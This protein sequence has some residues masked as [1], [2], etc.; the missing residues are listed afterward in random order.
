LIKEMVEALVDVTPSPHL[1]FWRTDPV[2]PAVSDGGQNLV[3]LAT[4]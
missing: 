1:P 4:Q 3:G 2:K